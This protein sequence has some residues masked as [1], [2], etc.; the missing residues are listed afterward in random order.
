MVSSRFARFRRPAPVA[1]VDV[2]KFEL[3]CRLQ[4]ALT[5]L[6]TDPSITG[7]F[8]IKT[9]RITTR[10]KLPKKCLVSFCR[11]PRILPKTKRTNAMQIKNGATCPANAFMV[12]R[13]CCKPDKNEATGPKLEN[14]FDSIDPPFL[15]SWRQQ[16]LGGRLHR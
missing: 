15:I 7:Q 13:I 5:A 11:N 9:T 2:K 3:T 1:F 10:S 14:R 6:L 16:L 12:G 8:P 4:S